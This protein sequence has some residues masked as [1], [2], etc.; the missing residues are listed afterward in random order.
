MSK[1][2]TIDKV[3][4]CF[5]RSDWPSARKLLLRE[6]RRYPHDSWLLTRLSFVYYNE[7]KYE[8]AL[9]MSEKA[10]R[11][12]PH[13]PV[14]LWDN[15]RAL[16]EKDRISESVRIFKTLIRMSVRALSAKGYNRRWLLGIKN[17]CRFW[18]AVGYLRLDRL[19][20]AAKYFRQNLANRKRGRPTECSINEARNFLRGIEK[21][22]KKITNNELRLWISLMEVRP[23]RGQEVARFKGAYTNGLVMAHSAR[24][25]ESRLKKRLGHMGYKVVSVEDTEEF[26]RRCLKFEVEQYLRKLAAKAKRTRS[27]QFDLFCTWGAVKN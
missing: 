4:E 17:D 23:T 13:D 5:S 2:E 26:E 25:A 3:Y 1:S 22:K 10:Y 19:D 24:E 18:V 16:L 20:L 15:A 21:L 14:V 8:K 27:A 7:Q 6:I 12:D 11:I 9:E